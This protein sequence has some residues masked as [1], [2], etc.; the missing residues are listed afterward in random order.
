MTISQSELLAFA[1]LGYQSRIA[2][3]DA[4]LSGH[5]SQA[6]PKA[7][8][9]EPLLQKKRRMSPA[10]KKRI[11]TAQKKRW[12]EFHAQKAQT[13]TPKK[14]KPMSKERRA[15][16]VANL[17]KARAARAAKRKAA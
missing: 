3:I 12:A 4:E 7:P 10:A 6:T 13:N 16:I 11:A 5:Q 9:A 17:A 15:A 1:R 14:A 2:E 8:L